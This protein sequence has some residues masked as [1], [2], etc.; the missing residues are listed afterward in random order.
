M[1]IIVLLERSHPVGVEPVLSDRREAEG[2]GFGLNWAELALSSVPS[3]HWG[4]LAAPIN[5]RLCPRVC[6]Q[7][8]DVSYSV[9]SLS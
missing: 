5:G 6:G 1:L 3:N 7:A 4:Q 9:S 2:L 8:V